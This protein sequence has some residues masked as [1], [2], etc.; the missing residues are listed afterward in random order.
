VGKPVSP[1]VA[2]FSARGPNSIAPAI[3]KV[4]FITQYCLVQALDMDQPEHKI[5]QLYENFPTKM[6]QAYFLQCILKLL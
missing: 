4:S 5:R 3:L 1:K 6:G 2:Y